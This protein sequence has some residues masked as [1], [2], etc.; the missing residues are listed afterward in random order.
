MKNNL[1]KTL[2]EIESDLKKLKEKQ[3]KSLEEI[4]ELKHNN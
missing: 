4:N 2:K 3:E 1:L